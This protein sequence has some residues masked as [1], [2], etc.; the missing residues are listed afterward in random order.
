MAKWTLTCNDN[1]GKFQCFDVVAKDKTT[2]IKKG[3]ERARK[4]AKGDIINWN[5][6]L[7]SM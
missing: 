1:G 2:A 3:L 7:K 5:C 6:H 4:K